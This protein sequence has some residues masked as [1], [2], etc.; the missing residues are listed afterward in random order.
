DSKIEPTKKLKADGVM[1]WTTI[2]DTDRSIS[3]K[4]NMAG[5][6]A[7]LFLIDKVGVIKERVSHRDLSDEKFEKFV[8]GN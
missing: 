7:D 6:P 5:V 2:S 1:T 4:W 3:D 8:K